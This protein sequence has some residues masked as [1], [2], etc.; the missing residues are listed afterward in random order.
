MTHARDKEE[1]EKESRY[2]R[3]ESQSGCEEN[4]SAAHIQ[5]LSLPLPA[6][7][8]E[9]DAKETRTTTTNKHND[10]MPGPVTRWESATPSIS[11]SVKP[12]TAERNIDAVVLGD[13]MF[14]A[15]YP[16]PY[17]KEIVGKEVVEE[18]KRAGRNNISEMMLERLYVCKWCFKYSREL[19]AW[20][21]HV[22]CCKRREQIPGRRVYTHQDGEWTVW[23]VD[24]EVDTNLS[25][26]AKLFLDNKSVFFDVT[27]FYYFLLVHTSPEKGAQQVI[28][29]FSKEKMSWDNN[30]LAC[31]L[32]FPPWQRKGLGALLIAVSYEISQ[33][34]GILGGPEK[35]ISDLGRKGYMT[36]WAGEIVRYLLGLKDAD[37]KNDKGLVSLEQISRETW[38]CVDDCLFALREM[39]VCMKVGKTPAAAKE[40]GAAQEVL[41]DK[42]ELRKYAA[43]MKITLDPII[44]PA[45]FLEDYG[46]RPG[47]DAETSV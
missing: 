3:K 33:R 45:G 18:N 29:F 22:G 14:N 34:E 7:H 5:R 6:R 2:V 4:P 15:W 42:E 30:N 1:E 25:L 41:V 12:S 32:I 44:D 13:V 35:P 11:S 9:G 23:E 10:Q 26:F 20:W 17:V 19:M 21:A 31:I 36:Y 40:I 28:G 38:I 37:R 46:R 24:G 16:S 47:S 39:S 43:F 8:R 27:G